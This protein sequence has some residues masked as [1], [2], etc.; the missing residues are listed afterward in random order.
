[1]KLYKQQIIQIFTNVKH[2]MVYRGI[3]YDGT[4]NNS[5]FKQWNIEG[6]LSIIGYYDKNGEKDKEWRHY[7]RTERLWKIE[8]YKHGK[9]FGEWKFFNSNGLWKKVKYDDDEN[10][11]YYATW[12]DDGNKSVEIDEE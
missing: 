12:D 6:T 7:D 1:M 3:W 4:E 10:I 5:L 11:I 8:N 9:R 2:L